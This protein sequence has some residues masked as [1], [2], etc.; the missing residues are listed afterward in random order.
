[1]R[2]G[3]HVS[4]EF[5]G[6]FII[7]MFLLLTFTFV[8]PT[9]SLATFSRIID[10]AYSPT[11]I[12]AGSLPLKPPEPVPDWIDTLNWMRFNL[13]PTDVVAS[14]WD[15]GYWITTIANKTTLADNGTIN[16][17][18]IGLIGQMFL[19]TEIEAI[20]ILR[21]FDASYVVVF[22]TFTQDGT[23]YGYADEGKWRWMARI[24]GLDDDSFGNY[25][26]GIDWVDENENGQRDEGELV[27]NAKGNSTVIYKLMNYGRDII[28]QGYSEIDL[29]YFVGPPQ[30]YFS[31]KYGESIRQY[32]DV[33][34]LV[35]VYKVDYPELR[36]Q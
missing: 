29:E 34:P 12:A 14:W 35:C 16:T 11:I 5:S 7:L 17:T 8:L 27:P 19:S 21:R 9:S 10:H 1:M 26:L 31:Q 3:A 6:A 4:R 36:A 25:A 32:G 23:D 13:Q 30:G 24:G 28:L 33:I 22:T 20:E 18:Q 15:Y 2:F